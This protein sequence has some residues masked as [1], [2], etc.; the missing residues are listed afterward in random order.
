ML[1]KSDTVNAEVAAQVT[2][3]VFQE[4]KKDPRKIV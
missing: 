4:R 3:R 1:T 2:S